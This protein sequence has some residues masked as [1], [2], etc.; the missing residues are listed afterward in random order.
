MPFGQLGGWP[1]WSRAELQLVTKTWQEGT[2][3]RACEG[4]A[5]CLGWSTECTKSL[6]PGPHQ[7]IPCGPGCPG[8]QSPCP[9]ALQMDRLH[10]ALQSWRPW[11]WGGWVVAWAKTSRQAPRSGTTSNLAFSIEASPS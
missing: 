1:W 11:G 8:R 9:R 2:G 6:F 5:A 10:V 7:W 4:D 3:L